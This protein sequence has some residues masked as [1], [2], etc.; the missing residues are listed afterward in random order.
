[1]G[2]R[3]NAIDSDVPSF[4]KRLIHSE[5]SILLGKLFIR[6]GFWGFEQNITVL[7][8]ITQTL[9]PRSK[10]VKDISE[11]PS[12]VRNWILKLNS[13]S[14]QGFYDLMNVLSKI[15]PEEAYE[16]FTDFLIRLTT[17]IFP[18]HLSAFVSLY[19]MGV[20]LAVLKRFES[21][22]LSEEYTQLRIK[23]GNQN[24]AILPKV[25]PENL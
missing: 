10:V 9:R 6:V 25:L 24:R 2:W 14:R 15:S 21:W 17:L 13:K 7:K 22:F 5:W 19:D 18:N 16:A 20:D 1:L 4:A 8:E 12:E 23:I 11:Y 3:K